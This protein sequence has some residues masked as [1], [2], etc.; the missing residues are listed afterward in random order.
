MFPK[1]W[2]GIPIPKAI[3]A[4]WLKSEPCPS[5]GLEAYVVSLVSTAKWAKTD[6]DVFAALPPAYRLL[7][8]YWDL[9][10]DIYNGGFQQYLC[11]K[12]RDGGIGINE[13]I[14]ATR[15]FGVSPVTKLLRK[16]IELMAASLPP[17]VLSTLSDLER[18]RALRRV[19]SREELSRRLDRVDQTFGMIENPC[20]KVDIYIKRHP[21]EFIHQ[22]LSTRDK[23]QQKNSC[24]KCC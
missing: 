9:Y 17:G 11:N 21:D 6:E 20:S 22:K 23:P 14:E 18:N 10:S 1:E 5:S 16:A 12:S 19:I 2:N 4:E 15:R 24:G 3:T 13:A 7:Y 8:R